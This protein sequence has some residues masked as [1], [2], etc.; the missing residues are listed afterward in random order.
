MIFS[1]ILLCLGFPLLAMAGTA[2]TRTRTT[3]STPTNISRFIPDLLAVDGIFLF[4]A[5]PS[6][7]GLGLRSDKGRRPIEPDAGETWCET[8]KR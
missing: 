7:I 2:I 1:T 4:G 6:Y 5:L 8:C 3:T